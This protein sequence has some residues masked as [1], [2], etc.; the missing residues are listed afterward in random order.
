MFMER[1]QFLS[2]SWKRLS[3]YQVEAEYLPV[4]WPDHQAI[5]TLLLRSPLF[6]SRILASSR[7]AAFPV[8]LSVVPRYQESMWPWTSMNFSGSS[9]PS[10]SATVKGIRLH[11][12]SDLALR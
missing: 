9:F 10:I 4:E 5:L 2:R 7:R 11:S 12:V 6:L 1:K 3:A 8:Q